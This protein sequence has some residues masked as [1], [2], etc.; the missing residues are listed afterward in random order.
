MEKKKKIK[1]II[2]GIILLILFTIIG[3]IIWYNISI[4]AVSKESQEVTVE[5]E[6]GSTSSSIAEELKEKDLIKNVSA[7]KIYIKL[8]KIT[9]F[10][11]GSYTLNKNMDVKEIIEALQT[12]VVYGDSIKITF[13]EGKTIRWYAKTIAEN[14]NYTEEEVFELLENEEYI[15]SLIQK[16]WFLTEEIKNPD[17]YYP[18]EGYLW[19]DTYLFD[20]KDITIQ[21]IFEKLLDQT[22]TKLEKYKEQIQNSGYSVHQILTLASMVEM[23]GTKEENRK[24]IAS[25]F[26]NRLKNNMPLGSDVTT[27]YA[28]KVEVGERDLYLSELNTYNAY[29]TRG[30]EMEGKLPVGPISSVGESSLEAVIY[31]NET[32]YLYFVADKEGNVYF[33]RTNAEHEEKVNELKS[34]GLWYE[35]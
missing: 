1:Y 26:Y 5:I 20:K 19:P 9:N 32:S 7:F 13:L 35:F 29:N 8:N 2:I 21:T 27:Y 33:S 11:A 3:S 4:K 16:Y 31:P 23:E 28:V 15:D 18:L 14:T 12:G 22:G 24:D 34:N 17:I 30:P 10:Q 6:L 25:V